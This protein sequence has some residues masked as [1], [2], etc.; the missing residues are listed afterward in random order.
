MTPLLHK[1]IMMKLDKNYRLSK[2][3]KRIMAMMAPEKVNAYKK[4]VIQADIIGSIQPRGKKSKDSK[5]N[6]TE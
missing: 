3:T 1:D 4:A 2:T 6:D 5:D